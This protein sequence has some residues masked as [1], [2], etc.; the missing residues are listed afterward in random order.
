MNHLNQGLV[1]TAIADTDTHSFGDLESAGA[2]TWTASSRTRSGTTEDEV[3]ERGPRRAR[4]GGQGL[5]VQ[6]RLL[7]ADGSGGVADLMLG[8]STT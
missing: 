8:S 3:G 5:Y 1:T 4:V 7:A 6:T 2:R